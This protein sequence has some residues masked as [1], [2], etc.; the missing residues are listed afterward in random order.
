VSAA[1]LLR[2]VTDEGWTRI[3]GG[4]GTGI[5]PPTAFDIAFTDNPGLK[6]ERSRSVDIGLEHALMRSTIVADVTWFANRYDDLIIVVGS[7]MSG[8]SRFQ[9]DNIANARS[10]GI[11]TGVRWQPS[12]AIAVRGSWTRL[13]TS[14]L[15]VDQVPGEAPPPFSVGDPLIR[16]PRQQGSLEVGWTATRGSAFFSVNGRGRML[17]LDPSFGAFGGLFDAPGYATVAAGGSWR[18][19]RGIDLTARISNLFDRE[20]EEALGFPALGRSV[21]VGVRVAG[22]R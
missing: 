12:A 1:W 20:Y 18:L 4:A 2:S 16:R 8:A 22:S 9:T 6:P 19:V 14:V 3:R 15:A 10:R 11:E 7:S 5:K 17:D 13:S 21:I